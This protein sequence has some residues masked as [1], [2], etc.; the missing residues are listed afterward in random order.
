M[1]LFRSQG[2]RCYRIGSWASIR[3]FQ[4]ELRH[5]T[6]ISN[7][8]RKSSIPSNFYPSQVSSNFDVVSIKSRDINLDLKSYEF[9]KSKIIAIWV[10]SPCNFE[11]SGQF[12]SLAPK[13]S[14]LN[15]NDFP[16]STTDYSVSLTFLNI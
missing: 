10:R 13:E 8:W 15:S 16:Y 4:I 2:K 7:V 3:A 14:P 11:Y 6:I 9:I 1:R 12:I 5:S